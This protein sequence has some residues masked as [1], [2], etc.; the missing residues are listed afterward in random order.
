[1]RNEERR[2]RRTGREKTGE[3][4]AE[5]TRGGEREAGREQEEAREQ[6]REE[7]KTYH[8]SKSKRATVV[9]SNKRIHEKKTCAVYLAGSDVDGKQ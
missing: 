9:A 3:K 6:E 4:N 2:T 1:M 7:K 8:D 5:T